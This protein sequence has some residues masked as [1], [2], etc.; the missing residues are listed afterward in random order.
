MLITMLNVKVYS[1]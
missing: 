1:I